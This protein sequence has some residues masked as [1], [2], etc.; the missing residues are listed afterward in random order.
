MMDQNISGSTSG[1]RPSSINDALRILDEALAGSSTKLKELVTDQYQNL[2]SAVSGSD[3]MRES[4]RGAG[5]QAYQQMS[6]IANQGA[7]RSREFYYDVDSRVKANPWPV[8][9]GV[10]L[11]TLALGFV[12]G[13][14]T[15]SELERTVSH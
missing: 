11:G 1:N 2:K 7:D 13:K 14:K 3:G 9:G 5:Q 15:S 8:I 6:D 12:I 10:A 4:I